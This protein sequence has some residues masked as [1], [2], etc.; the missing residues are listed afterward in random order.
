MHVISLFLYF[1]ALLVSAFKEQE[2]KSSLREIMRV[3]MAMSSMKKKCFI[4]ALV[5]SLI[6]DVGFGG[7][8]FVA[9]L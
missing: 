3:E 1:Q 6:M 9:E 4:F 2:K 8:I 7:G 5:L